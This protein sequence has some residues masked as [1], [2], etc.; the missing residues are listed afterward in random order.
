[1]NAPLAGIRIVEV[2]HMLAG[3]YCGLMLA[4][5][6]AEVIKIEAPE[7]DIA[8]TVSPHF[9]GPHNA[10]F[11]SLNRNKKSVVLDLASDEG[12]GT[13]GLDV[14]VIDGRALVT[15]VDS[16]SS[17]E[18]AGVRP[19]WIVDRVGSERM[20]ESI[21]RF[22]AQFATDRYGELALT[23]A[24]RA[25]LTGEVGRELSLTLLDGRGRRVRRRLA[26]EE[27]PGTP[28]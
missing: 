22:A 19:G 8:R 14:R 21:E 5:L 18:R 28:A 10:Y 4:D 13:V 3:P 1:M 6:G 2:G 23:A 25:R 26:L 11:A 16:R 17:A 12:E 27:P 24:L 7:G 15:S 9:V 20:S